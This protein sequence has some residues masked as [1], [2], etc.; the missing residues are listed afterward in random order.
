M[1]V[2]FDWSLKLRRVAVA[3]AGVGDDVVGVGG[4]LCDDGVVD[5]AALLVEE[6]GERGGVRLERG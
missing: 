4:V 2:R 6:N 3:P 5:D 1:N